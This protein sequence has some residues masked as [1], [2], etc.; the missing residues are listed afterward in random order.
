MASH[1][2]TRIS[3]RSTARSNSTTIDQLHNVELNRAVPFG[4]PIWSSAPVS[5]VSSNQGGVSSLQSTVSSNS[6]LM[7]P[8][9]PPPPPSSSSSSS[10]FSTQIWGI[11]NSASYNNGWNV[12]TNSPSPSL[13]SPSSFPTTQ[14]DWPSL[15]ES[16]QQSVHGNATPTFTSPK[17]SSIQSFPLRPNTW[18]AITKQ[19]SRSSSKDSNS[20]LNQQMN[21]ANTSNN[22]SL[23][24]PQHH[25]FR[26]NTTNL[27]RFA[28]VYVPQILRDISN[29]H[30][31]RVEHPRD[32]PLQ[33]PLEYAKAI[34][35]QNLLDTILSEKSS[36][37][38]QMSS[39]TILNDIEPIHL[40]KLCNSSLDETYAKKL[41][42]M[43]NVEFLQRQ[44][45]LSS[46][47]LYNV[48]ISAAIKED[49]PSGLFKLEAPEIREGY[50]ALD[51]NDVVF[52]RHI[53]GSPTSVVW[54][55]VLYI[56]SVQAVQRAAGIVIVK[57]PAIIQLVHSS[58]QS[59]IVSFEPQGE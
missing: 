57:C 50:P 17:S 25:S 34:Y 27:D 23:H 52:L 5:T 28:T 16:I 26:P 41:L 56:A 42:K 1:P 3:S 55:G 36:A 43:Q 39:E 59:F 46:S 4:N 19:T 9:P 6:R 7:S 20:S 51:I 48:N 22:A 53:R 49:I 10:S 30:P 29:A 54:D 15:S 37:E 13:L 11:A 47:T 31:S 40:E 14:N 8:P 32:V 38:K 35:P 58:T 12:H 21:S 44:D 24:N 33:D 2:A 45:D 18:S